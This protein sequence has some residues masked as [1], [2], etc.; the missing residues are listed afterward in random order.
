M[1]PEFQYLFCIELQKK[2]REK[3]VG[4]IYVKVNPNDDLVVDIR[5]EYENIDYRWKRVDISNNIL[6]GYNS[7]DAVWE[8]YK[9][10]KAYINKHFFKESSI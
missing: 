6:R 3:I 8:I 2:L 4:N 5:L 10:Y 7:D 9:S 1:M